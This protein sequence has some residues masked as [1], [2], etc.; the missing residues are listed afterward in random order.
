MSTTELVEIPTATALEVYTADGGL[1]PYLKTIQD[2]V[3]EELKALGDPTDV[4]TKI[5]RAAIAS[6][7]HKI[8][9]SRTY[10]DDKVGKELAASAKEIPKKIDAAR[11]LARDT[12]QALQDKVRKPLTEWEAAEQARV[13]ALEAKVT[14]MQAILTDPAQRTSAE[15][16]NMIGDIQKVDPSMFEEYQAAAL[17]AK[18][19]ALSHLH[20]RLDAVMKAEAEA[21]ELEVLRKEKAAREQKEREERIA[22]EAAEKARKNAEESAAKA[23]RDAEAREKAAQEAQA[24]AEREAQEAKA[25]AAKAEQEAAER[26]Q[27]AAE[28]ARLAAEQEAARKKQEEADAAAKRESNKRHYAKVNNGAAAALVEHAGLTEAQ[29]K[30]VV[31]AIAQKKIANVSIAY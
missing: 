22:A 20:K 25:R 9:K 24:R 30:A 28:D 18:T 29:A 2:K 17:S 15:L 21:A 16:E 26:A 6:L 27:K 8:A 31:T 7:S 19:A 12:L 10:L 14:S 11:R 23:Q 13:D 5:K 3:A 1:M 4:S